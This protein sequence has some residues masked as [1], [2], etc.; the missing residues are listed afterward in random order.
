MKKRLT[1]QQR[2]ELLVEELINKML[3]P[4]GVDK[5]WVIDN[6]E[7]IYDKEG[8][9]IEMKIEGVPWYQHFTWSEDQEKAWC[10]YAV[11]RLRKEL[12]FTKPYATRYVTMLSLNWGLKTVKQTNDD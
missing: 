6:S 4:Y 1:R 7:K 5:Q 3:E 8:R 11:T 12:K 2:E 10:N 9:P